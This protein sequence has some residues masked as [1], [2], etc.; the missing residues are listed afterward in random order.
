M[1]FCI[2]MKLHEFKYHW[3][4]IRDEF[5]KLPDPTDHRWVKEDDAPGFLKWFIWM[6]NKPLREENLCPKTTNLVRNLHED[7]QFAAFSV[8]MGK[9]G[10]APHT[11]TEDN[12][13]TYKCTYHLGIRC[14]DKCFIH[15]SKDGRM[16]ERD[17]KE[18]IFDNRYVHYAKNESEK[19]R[20]IFYMTLNH[21]KPDIMTRVKRLFT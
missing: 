7:I 3:K 19:G 18:I 5:N 4:T 14:P 2:S 11:D 1:Y 13:E 17:G 8:F 15:H 21:D 16:Y 20:V 10:L 9:C 12:N 6:D